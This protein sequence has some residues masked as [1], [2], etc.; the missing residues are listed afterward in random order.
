[1]KCCINAPSVVVTFRVAASQKEGAG[2]EKRRLRM[3]E[4]GGHVLE[5]GKADRSVWLMKCPAM[6]SR[7]WQSA[8]TSATEA[9]PKP[10]VAKVV[11]F[12]DLVTDNETTGLQASF[13][14]D[15]VHCSFLIVWKNREIEAHFLPVF[16]LRRMHFE[17]RASF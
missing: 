16:P 8:A 13:S 11:V 14:S 1:M 9:V 7:L 10:V 6:V 12:Q 3:G 2:G 15:D 4:T 5:T 17:G